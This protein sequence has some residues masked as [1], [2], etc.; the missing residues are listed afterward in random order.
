MTNDLLVHLARFAGHL[1]S[2]GLAIGVGDEVDAARALLL[3][4]LSDR[5]EVHRALRVVLK[6]H[7]R[8]WP[9]F[10][11]L[12]GRL[13][14]SA[15][16]RSMPKDRRSSPAIAGGPGRLDLSHGLDIRT[17]VE[18]STRS[19]AAEPG[20]SP[21][22]VLRR[23]PF[24][25]CSAGDLAAMEALLARLARKLA[26]HRSRR[27]V[28]S[29]LGRITDLRRSLRRAIDTGGELVSLAY[30]ARAIERPELVVLC[31]TSGSMDRHARFLLA[32][33]VALRRV[34]R[35]TEVF[36]FNTSL[37]RVTSSIAAGQI[38]RTLDR[39][40]SGV[41]DW[42]G[43]TKIGESLNEFVSRHLDRLVSRKSVVIIFSDGLDRGDTSLV[44]GAMRAIRAR[45]GRVIWLNPLA[46]DARY[47]PTA[48]A[49]AA[50][51]P[52]IHCL[53]AAHDLESLERLLPELA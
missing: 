20:Y 14:T 26:A 19:A 4:D 7:R 24:D 1:R 50:A 22:H 12:F 2:R 25:E 34:A 33:A 21:D 28:P 30:R 41:P 16:P 10:D 48:R 13:W 11:E 9:V 45:A 17:A 43:G 53:A 27:L 6:V 44:A 29:R 52:F 36:V 8:D 47:E 32:F 46:G 31:D 37:R 3:V 15:V 5:A 51:R 49:M 39:L 42:S 40:E 38:G 23:K 35:N 18:R